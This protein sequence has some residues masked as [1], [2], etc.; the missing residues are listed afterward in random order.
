MR[1]YGNAT[2]SVKLLFRFFIFTVREAGGKFKKGISKWLLFTHLQIKSYP[3]E[4]VSVENSLH[5]LKFNLEEKS[6]GPAFFS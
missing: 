4:G 3:R 5:K 2:L 6:V 1:R